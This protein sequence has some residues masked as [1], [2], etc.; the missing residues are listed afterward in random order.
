LPEPDAEQ[1]AQPRNRR[2]LTILARIVV[3]VAL[4]SVLFSRVDTTELWN[5]AK[6][7]SV[8]WL[9][10]ALALYFVHVLASTWRWRVLL[11]AQGVHVPR[12]SLL[13]SYL[14]AIFFNNFLPS[15]IG[16]DVVRI[17]DTAGRARSKTLATTVIIVD[18]GLGLLGL[19]LMAALGAT[20]LGRAN[21][22]IWPVWLW[23]GFFAAIAAAAPALLA[24]AGVGRLLEPLSRID[25]WVAQRIEKLT[26]ALA[27][28][29][30]RPG[31]LAECF[32]GVM[33]VQ[34]LLIGYHF[35]VVN[36]LHLPVGVWDLAVI[37]PLSFIVQMVP[38][39][40]N[41]FGVRE[42]TFSLYFA[43]L[44]L[45]L[46]AGVLVSLSATVLTMIFSLSGAALYM[47]QTDR[48]LR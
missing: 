38:V 19:V 41:G 18:R 14:V 27:R 23:A 11:D 29:R 48:H 6:Q 13:S 21:S 40:L 12:A 15:N 10:F 36:A 28:F 37:V 1:P 39:S 5:N 4:L 44:G 16:G 47:T 46:Q 20:A 17:S 31:A 42:A 33:C 3:S 2:R 43:R 34:A 7:A 45:P 24:P 26:A 22:P 32:A 9:V 35:A 30:D 25:P 8:S